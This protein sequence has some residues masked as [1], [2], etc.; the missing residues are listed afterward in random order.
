MFSKIEQAMQRYVDDEILPG[1][2]FMIL[3]GAD[4]VHEGQVGFSDI[5]SKA[6]LQRDVGHIRTPNVVR[7]RDLQ[8]A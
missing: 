8:I 1:V 2:S 7:P 5:E 4:I 3:K 6:P